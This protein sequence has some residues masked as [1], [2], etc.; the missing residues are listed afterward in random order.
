MYIIFNNITMRGIC[1]TIARW[2]AVVRVEAVIVVS[3]ILRN[4]VT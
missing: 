4:G 2:F 3:Q 1:Y